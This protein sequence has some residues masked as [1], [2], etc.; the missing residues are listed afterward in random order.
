MID[1]MV[2][3]GYSMTD[4][5]ELPAMAIEVLAD[6]AGARAKA[7]LIRDINAHRIAGADAKGYKEAIRSIER[8]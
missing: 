6:A 2:G 3:A 4:I 7:G 1:G 5:L 8:G